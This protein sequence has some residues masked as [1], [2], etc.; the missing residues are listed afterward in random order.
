MVVQ[1]EIERFVYEAQN[2]PT[3]AVWT[4][5]VT[6]AG[7]PPKIL[8]S[9]INSSNIEFH[10]VVNVTDV[11][12]ASFPPPHRFRCIKGLATWWGADNGARQGMGQLRAEASAY[13]HEP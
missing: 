10:V 4:S 8:D 2:S 7:S 5:V 12:L 3:S 9:K 11:D 6:S 13:V 1:R